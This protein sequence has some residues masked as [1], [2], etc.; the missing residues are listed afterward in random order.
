MHQGTLNHMFVGTGELSRTLWC[1]IVQ[2]RR[3]TI[4]GLVWVSAQPIAATLLR[5]GI[6]MLCH[7]SRTFTAAKMLGQ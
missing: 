4:R 5:L 2:L 6:C 3:G 7:R 1:M